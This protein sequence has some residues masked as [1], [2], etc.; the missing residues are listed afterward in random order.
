MLFCTAKV[1][2]TDFVGSTRYN[3]RSYMERIIWIAMY[4][5]EDLSIEFVCALNLLRIS[6]KSDLFH[7]RSTFNYLRFGWIFDGISS[8]M[9]Q[10]SKM[11]NK[12]RSTHDESKFAD[13][14][15]NTN[16][17]YRIEFEWKLETYAWPMLSQNTFDYEIW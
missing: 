14:H 4:R 15:S 6:H 11:K 8:L 9:K 3:L 17:P 1:I 10:K 7:S 12:Q 5:F 2:A 13:F 16:F